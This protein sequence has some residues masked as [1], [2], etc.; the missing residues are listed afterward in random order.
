M[1]RK[2]HY[3]HVEQVAL[4]RWLELCGIRFFA[5]PMGGHRHAAVGK[6]LKSEGARKGVPDLILVDLAPERGQPVAIEMK[7]SRGGQVKPHQ[8][9]W[10]EAM[11]ERGWIVL[12]AEGARHAEAMLR[13]L[14]YGPHIRRR[15]RG[16]EEQ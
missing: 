9:E 8:R 15:S 11:T 16:K 1:S 6:A 2:S 3:E 5:V 10:H 14:G 7:R 13:I 4:V 12:V